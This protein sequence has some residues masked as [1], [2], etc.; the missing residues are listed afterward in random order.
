V[1]TGNEGLPEKPA[2]VTFEYVPWGRTGEGKDRE[3]DAARRAAVWPDATD[4]DLTEP[5]LKD[6]LQ[7]RLPQLLID[8]R[9]AVESIGLKWE[10]T[11]DKVKA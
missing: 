1:E 7:A 2:P 4:E 11:E 6:R 8:F 3:L 5:G 10:P 9:A